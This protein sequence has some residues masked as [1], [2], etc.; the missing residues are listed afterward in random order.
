MAGLT[1]PTIKV[2]TN[3]NSGINPTT[4]V[5]IAVPV[6]CSGYMLKNTGPDT[7]YMRSNPSDASTEDNMGAGFYEDCLM[8][9]TGFYE[10][11]F[12]AGQVIYWVKCTG[13]LILKVW[14]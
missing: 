12:Q 10:R 14:Y 9:G 6:D 2:F 13:P 8:P 3:A 1:N 4:F 7:L 5:A 11:R